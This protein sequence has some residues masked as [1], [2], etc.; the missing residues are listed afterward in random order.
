[1]MATGALF[2]ATAER[3]FKM[4]RNRQMI[5]TV[6]PKQTNPETGQNTYE[7]A[8][9]AAEVRPIMKFG[10]DTLQKMKNAVKKHVSKGE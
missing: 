9:H 4:I 6:D 8:K 1:M 10:E 3:P 7:Y 2:Y 5:V